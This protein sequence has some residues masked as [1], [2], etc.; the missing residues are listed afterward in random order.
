MVSVLIKTDWAAAWV[1][2]RVKERKMPGNEN[3]MSMIIRDRFV[4]FMENFYIP[5]L[6]LAQAAKL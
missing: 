6:R 2:G 3:A 4:L 5:K 1:T